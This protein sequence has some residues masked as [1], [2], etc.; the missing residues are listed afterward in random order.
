MS[1]APEQTSGSRTPGPTIVRG[2]GRVLRLANDN[3]RRDEDH[4]ATGG[5]VREPGVKLGIMRVLAKV[6]SGIF[7]T[8]TA[9]E[10][11]R[12][13]RRDARPARRGGHHR[14]HIGG[15]L[16]NRIGSLFAGVG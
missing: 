2:R 15:R 7:Q 6:L 3:R 12:S 13:C 14:F 9:G 1:D 4:V 5:A 11:I 16:Q 8:D 10:A